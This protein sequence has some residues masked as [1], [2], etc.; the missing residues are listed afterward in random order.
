MRKYTLALVAFFACVSAAWAQSAGLR[1]LVFT[2]TAGFHHTSI[3]E[4][5]DGLR[6]LAARHSFQLDWQ[7]NASVFNDEALKRYDAVVFLSTTGD[8][9]NDEQQAAFERYIQSGHG[10]VGVHAA[11]D[12]EYDWEWYTKMVGMMFKI[13][14]RQQTAYLDILD[15]NF[16]G[17]TRFPK[18]MMWTDEWYQYQQPVLSNDLHYLIAVDESSY[19]PEAKWG[20]NEGKGM[21]KFHPMSWYHEYDGGR[22]FYTGL[23]HIGEIFKDPI[24]L[25]HL[26]GG[27][28]WA[29]TGK[30]I[31]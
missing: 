12:T 26:Y 25:D 22:A 21:G 14:P 6:F 10:W 23:G 7:E 4:G 8:I 17:M 11:A 18:R 24:Y 28:Y 5:I 31:K 27:I 9:L 20:D 2:K 15:D 29:A 3:H 1:I 30:G 16:P 19:E 13:H